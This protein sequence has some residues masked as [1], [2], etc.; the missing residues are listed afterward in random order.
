MKR[1][2]VAFIDSIILLCVMSTCFYSEGIG[3]PTMGQIQ[4]Q[5]VS[6]ASKEHWWKRYLLDI[7]LAF[8]AAILLIILHFALPIHPHLATILL[9]F[10]FIMLWLVHKRGF[11]TPILI[12][13]IA[14]AVLDFLVVPPSFS[15]WVSQLEDGWQ[16]LTFLLFV[17]VLS[18]S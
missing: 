10:L 17:I 16:L 3:A 1:V 4:H 14:C 6:E 5:E 9:V 18:F 8:M 13:L 15:F 11:R 2:S 7:L 12:A